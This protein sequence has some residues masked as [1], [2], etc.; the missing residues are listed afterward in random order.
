MRIGEVIAAPGGVPVDLSRRIAGALAV[1]AVEGPPALF[2]TLSSLC[3]TFGFH[4]RDGNGSFT[5]IAR[6]FNRYLPYLV[7]FNRLR[8]LCPA[9]ERRGAWRGDT[10]DAVYEL[11]QRQ[12]AGPVAERGRVDCRFC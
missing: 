3:G 6:H 4:T 11:A 8:R 9:N 1:D 5:K 7:K 12:A 2:Q 10:L